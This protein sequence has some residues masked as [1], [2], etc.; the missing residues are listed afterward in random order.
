MCSTLLYRCQEV[1]VVP[2]LRRYSWI[3][4]RSSSSFLQSLLG[5]IFSSD[6]RSFR[7]FVGHPTCLGLL[8]AWITPTEARSSTGATSRPKP[9]EPCMCEC[10]YKILQGITPSTSPQL[11]GFQPIPP[12]KQSSCSQG[13]WC[14]LNTLGPGCTV[15]APRPGGSRRLE[16]LREGLAGLEEVV[17]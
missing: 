14:T 7:G 15:S 11:R 13:F 2:N 4:E 6:D 10:T 8:C 1:P 12:T 16:R 3:R 9:F 5:R 17:V